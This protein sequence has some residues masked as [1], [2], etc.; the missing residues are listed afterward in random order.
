MITINGNFDFITR[1]ESYYPISAKA[2]YIVDLNVNSFYDIDE[3]NMSYEESDKL[4][5]EAIHE[6]YGVYPTK[7]WVGKEIKTK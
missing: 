1:L 4:I 5:G 2:N 6:K 3:E 7:I